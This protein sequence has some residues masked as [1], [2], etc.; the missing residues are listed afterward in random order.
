MRRI[1]LLACVAMGLALASLVGAQAA[2]PA[3]GNSPGRR[4]PC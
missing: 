3:I 2:V 4:R 1:V